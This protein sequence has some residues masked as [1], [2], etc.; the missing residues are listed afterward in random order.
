MNRL[1]TPCVVV[2]PTYNERENVEKLVPALLA[3][4]ERVSVLVVDDNSP[5]GTAEVAERFARQDSRVDVLRRGRPEGIGP[6]YKAGFARALEQGARYVVQMDADFSH[7]VHVVSE[8]LGC[9]EDCDMVLGSRY[10][11]GI[12]VINWPIERLLLSYFGNWYARKVTGL[13]THDVTGGFKCWRREALEGIGLER[14]R[15][16]GYAFQI[17][18]TYRA[19]KRGYRIR[20]IPIIFADRTLGDSKMN[21]RIALEA[22]WI[23]WWLRLQAALGRL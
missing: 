4:D 17:E 8:F 16:N 1:S 12:T 2:V 18:T 15:S 9:I 13:P 20:E 7:P 11:K 6:A 14:V 3:Q 19:W 23:V 10:L 22:L 21:K 5:D